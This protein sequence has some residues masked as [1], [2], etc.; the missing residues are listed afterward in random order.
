MTANGAIRRVFWLATALNQ[1]GGGDRFVVE[2]TKHFE[3]QGI[4]TTIA[5]FDFH[6]NALFDSTYQVNVVYCCKTN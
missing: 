5:T 2:G 3:D 1:A 4:E 6:Q